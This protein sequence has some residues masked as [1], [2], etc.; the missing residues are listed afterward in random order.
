MISQAAQAFNRSTH[1]LTDVV[2]LAQQSPEEAADYLRQ[3]EN[4]IEQQAATVPAAAP[5]ESQLEAIIN[6]TG[7]LADAIAARAA[8][9]SP[10]FPSPATTQVDTAQAQANGAASVGFNATPAVPGKP[11][12]VTG[13]VRNDN[14]M[15]R[16]DTP[17]GKSLLLAESNK[18][19]S[20]VSFPRSWLDGM[21]SDGP[22]TVKGTFGADGQ[23][24]NVEEYALN[25]DGR[26]NTLTSGRVVVS[27]GA[28]QVR[29]PDGASIQGSNPVFVAAF[30]ANPQLRLYVAQ[31]S[32]GTDANP[33]T[34]P[35][36]VTET[37]TLL[38]GQPIY[39]ST[40]RASYPN[41][42]LPP[43]DAANPAAPWVQ[44]AVSVISP[45]S[46]QLD[47]PQGM[48]NVSHPELRTKLAGMPRLGLIV[49]GEA[50]VNGNGDQVYE[51][52]P[53][54]YFGLARFRSGPVN[55]ANTQVPTTY[56]TG[57]M[58]YS[59]FQN[60][61]ITIPPG[62]AEDRLN[63]TLRFWAEGDIKI[64]PDY[65]PIQFDSS[66]ISQKTD[67][68]YSLSGPRA[69][70]DLFRNDALSIDAGHP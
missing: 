15:L 37:G 24:F 58:A 11:V 22:I 18:R 17:S 34:V 3:L 25:R 30:T 19:V 66:Y 21:K 55:P 65:R 1:Q 27:G 31:V 67:T 32:V 60:Q 59:I 49:P 7:N 46:V 51:L 16:L 52:N 63:H 26:Y 20:T 2:Q 48:L 39:D 54:P 6:Q 36:V 29:T 47:T 12:T 10:L 53:Q 62:V 23:S 68:F 14:G 57:D 38:A 8:E 45:V 64:G 4:V 40:G 35:V 5:L 9:L 56:K 61:P 41:L 42:V 70:A 44:A 43:F 50:T 33:Q 28:F 13:T 69:D